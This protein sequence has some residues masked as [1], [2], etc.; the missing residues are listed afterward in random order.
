MME[1]DVDIDVII[2]T[3]ITCR[4]TFMNDHE[5]KDKSCLLINGSEGKAQ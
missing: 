2:Q 4:R 3:Y 5:A 1:E